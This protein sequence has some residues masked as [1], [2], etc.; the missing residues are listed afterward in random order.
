MGHYGYIYIPNAC[1]DVD[2]GPDC[3]SLIFLHGCLQ[4][5]GYFGDA[6]AKRTGLLEYA[7][8]NNIIVVFP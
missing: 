1:L 2:N 7:A 8:T 6:E 3:H 4:G 5:A